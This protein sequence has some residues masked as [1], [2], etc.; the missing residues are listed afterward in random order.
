MACIDKRA[1]DGRLA[2]FIRH[3][4]L[5]F[6]F[7][8]F[9]PGKSTVLISISWFSMEGISLS[10]LHVII[11]CT[12]QSPLWWSQT[13]LVVGGNQNNTEKPVLLFVGNLNRKLDGE[14][15]T[16]VLSIRP[17]STAPLSSNSGTH[18]RSAWSCRSQHF[19]E[20]TQNYIPGCP[21]AILCG[22]FLFFWLIYF[23]CKQ[24]FVLRCALMASKANR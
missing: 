22:T 13:S 23:W 8:L 17:A 5:F 9:L 21:V 2:L 20:T 1:A 24:I 7:R 4:I 14:H 11:S 10:L 16:E 12:G 6:S 3:K 19:F 15:E 18:L